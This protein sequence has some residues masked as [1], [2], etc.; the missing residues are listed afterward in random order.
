[1][2]RQELMVPTVVNHVNGWLMVYCVQDEYT[3]PQYALVYTYLH[4]YIYMTQRRR[5]CRMPLRNE[6][7]EC[8]D[9]NCDV[10][11]LRYSVNEFSGIFITNKS[12]YSSDETPPLTYRATLKLRSYTEIFQ[13]D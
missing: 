8:M 7:V 6:P 2:S 13:P 5:R 10:W 3:K 1:M 4:V 11:T 12:A 9:T